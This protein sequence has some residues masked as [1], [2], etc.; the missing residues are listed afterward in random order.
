MLDEVTIDPMWKTGVGAEL[1]RFNPASPRL[2]FDPCLT[3]PGAVDS[4]KLSMHF[5]N[6]H[7]TC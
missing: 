7:S 6:T 2:S 1:H 4:F 5:I 3:V